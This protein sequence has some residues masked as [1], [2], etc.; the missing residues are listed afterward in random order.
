MASK[1]RGLIC[2]GES[3]RSFLDDRK[4][5]TRRVIK[6]QPE[7]KPSFYPKGKLSWYWKNEYIGAPVN[8]KDNCPYGQVG[9]RL[10]VKEKLIN[11][12]EANSCV[13][14]AYYADETK[15]IPNDGSINGWGWKTNTLSPRFMPKWAARIWLEIIGVR[16]ERVQDIKRNDVLAEGVDQIHID[17]YLRHNFHPDDAHGLAFKELWDSI[18][19][20]RGYGWEV[21]PWVWIL[22]LKKVK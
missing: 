7:E 14:V 22:E 19:A 18:N 21:N 11:W 1:E 17:K 16:V 2:T 6:P 20:K 5:Q 4:S 10:Y 9:D 12:C 8:L 3:V 13:S 15:V